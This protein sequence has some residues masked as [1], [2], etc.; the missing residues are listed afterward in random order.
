MLFIRL[1]CNLIL[2][3]FS[4]MSKHFFFRSRHDYDKKIELSSVTSTS[5]KCAPYSH[6]TVHFQ[7]VAELHFCEPLCLPEASKFHVS[8][9]TEN[10]I[11]LQTRNREESEASIRM[12][13]DL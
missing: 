11:A 13:N 10:L 9:S 7:N 2:T 3:F 8:N 6:T 1:K 12:S 5:L 4:R